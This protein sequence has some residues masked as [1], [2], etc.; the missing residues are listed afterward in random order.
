MSIFPELLSLSHIFFGCLVRT[1]PFSRCSVHVC[2]VEVLDLCRF[3][4]LFINFGLAAMFLLSEQ[5]LP[6]V[7]S[8]PRWSGFVALSG[9]F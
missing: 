4:V 3:N 2:W 6:L 7:V 8:L 5:Q 1:G 9:S